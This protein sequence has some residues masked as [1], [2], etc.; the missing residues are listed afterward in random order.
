M[1]ETI[2]FSDNKYS[3]LFLDYGNQEYNVEYTALYGMPE[4]L[5]FLVMSVQQCYLAGIAPANPQSKL[6]LF[7]FT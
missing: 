4:N 6:K 5:Q 3:V 1:E 2:N 7:L